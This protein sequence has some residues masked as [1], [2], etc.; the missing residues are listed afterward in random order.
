[1]RSSTQIEMIACPSCG[2][3]RVMKKVSTFASSVRG[4]SSPA[5]SSASSDCSTGGT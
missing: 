2:S 3:K 1:M 4:G 5:G